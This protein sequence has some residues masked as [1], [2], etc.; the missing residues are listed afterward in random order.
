M[1]VSMDQAPVLTDLPPART[2]SKNGP[3]GTASVLKA[4]QILDVFRGCGAAMGVSDIARR[5]DVPTST[6][7]TWSV[8]DAMLR[9]SVQLG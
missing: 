5:A 4:L 6:V 7:R 1:T 9:E 8:R 3:Q 2:P